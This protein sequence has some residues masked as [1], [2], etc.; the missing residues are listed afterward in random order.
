MKITDGKALQYTGCDNPIQR[1]II[2]AIIITIIITNIA[3]IIIAIII[4]INIAII[5][6]IIISDDH[7][8]KVHLIIICKCICNL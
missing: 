6:T 2:I 7:L 1:T 5:I 8:W 4:A 3:A